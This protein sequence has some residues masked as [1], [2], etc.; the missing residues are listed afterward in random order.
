M[1]GKGTDQ[2]PPPQY[3]TDI[4]WGL[5]KRGGWYTGEQTGDFDPFGES[6]ELRATL[7]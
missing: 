5:Q 6:K 1:V 4:G 3:E 7:N 2:M